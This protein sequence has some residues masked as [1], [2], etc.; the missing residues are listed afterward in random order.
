LFS[1]P[2]SGGLARAKALTKEGWARFTVAA[3]G[4]LF[5]SACAAILAQLILGHP[6]G[7]PSETGRAETTP[8]AL[9]VGG[10]FGGLLLLG[11]LSLIRREPRVSTIVLRGAVGA[12]CGG[13][14]A[15]LGAALT[16]SLG[17]W[18]ANLL[19]G[20]HL[21]A[22]GDLLYGNSDFV[23]AVFTVWQTGMAAVIA[24]MLFRHRS[25][26]EETATIASWF[27]GQQ[28]SNSA[29]KEESP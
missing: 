9:F 8:A 24:L 29:N 26:P 4:T 14:L 28:D 6:M 21:A 11:T 19:D 16:S 1:V 23:Y 22:R 25:E 7:I 27:G 15:R 12:L 18:F 3:T 17:S 10:C 20:W 13:L 5:L 2:L